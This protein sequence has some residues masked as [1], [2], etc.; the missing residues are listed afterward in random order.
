MCTR[1]NTHTHN[2]VSEFEVNFV[3]DFL[4]LIIVRYKNVPQFG[5]SITTRR[6]KYVENL[7][8]F[9]RYNTEREREK[10]RK[11]L[12]SDKNCF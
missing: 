2:L 10:R 6:I 7:K 3:L 1:A 4:S 8:R 11:P 5:I 12:F 9:L